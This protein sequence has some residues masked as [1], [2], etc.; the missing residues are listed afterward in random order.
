MAKAK[1]QYVA[2]GKD[3]NNEK[4]NLYDLL[5]ADVPNPFGTSNKEKFEEFINTAAVVD[6]QQMAI[7]AGISGSGTR[8]TLQENL[9]RAFARFILPKSSQVIKNLERVDGASV[10]KRIDEIIARG[11]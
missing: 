8:P 2:D 6:L 1:K 9:R 5:V 4:V 11:Y 7:K 10:G 3:A